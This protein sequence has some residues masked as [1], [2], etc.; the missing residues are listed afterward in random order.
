MNKMKKISALTKLSFN[1]KEGKVRFT[2]MCTIY[3]RLFLCQ[4]ALASLV[5]ISGRKKVSTFRAHPFQWPSKGIYPH[6]GV[7]SAH[8]G[9]LGG[10]GQGLR[11]GEDK[12]IFA[13]LSGLMGQFFLS[14]RSLRSSR[15]QEI[16]QPQ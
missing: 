14:R 8:V 12:R 5:A 1:E 6:Q 4:I 9:W 11:F 2:H 16:F 10:G 15:L 3:L 13:V 7:I